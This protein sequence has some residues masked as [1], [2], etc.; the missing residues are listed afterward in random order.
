MPDDRFLHRRAGHSEKVSLLTDLEFRVWTQY[1]L[2]ADDFGVM[3]ASAITLQSDNDH[4][5]NRPQKVIQ[6]CL[7]RLVVIGLIRTFEHQG[8]RYV[9]QHDWQT[10]QKVEYPRA[11]NDPKPVAECLENCEEATRRLFDIHPGGKSRRTPKRLENIPQIIPEDIPATRAGA[12]AKWLT[13]NGE[14]LMANGSEGSSRETE[15]TAAPMDLWTRELINLYPAQ[16]RCGWNVVERPLYEAL[17]ADPQLTVAAAWEALKGRLE[18]HKR[19]HQWRMKGMI[20]R[21][22]R[23]LREGTHLQE[24]PE[25]APVIDQV[26]TKTSRTLSAAANIMRSGS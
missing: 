3:R 20:P 19:S 16:G 15:L 12:P 10:W 9:Y 26:S 24:L 13:A 2:S 5:A 23:Y 8:R 18:G 7:D 25:D 21:L 6:R 17:T 4:L 22:D 14:R 1:L 11:T